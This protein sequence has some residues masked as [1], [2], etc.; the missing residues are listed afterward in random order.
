M[1]TPPPHTTPSTEVKAK[2]TVEEKPQCTHLFVD[3]RYRP[4]A[5]I[6]ARHVGEDEDLA[7]HLKRLPVP[8]A[9]YIRHEVI[10]GTVEP[11]ELPWTGSRVSIRRD[12]PPQSLVPSGPGCGYGRVSGQ[13]GSHHLQTA[14]SAVRSG[15]RHVLLG[16]V[17]SNTAGFS[18]ERWA[19]TFLT[20]PS[21]L[22]RYCTLSEADPLVVTRI[23]QS[24]VENQLRYTQFLNALL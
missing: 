4:L 6:I 18:N 7:D 14:T 3:R 12:G 22:Y 5:S 8:E 23:S 11:T 10:R 21:F 9:A 16:T 19:D 2:G 20:Q 24:E 1:T 17:D 15:C 13:T